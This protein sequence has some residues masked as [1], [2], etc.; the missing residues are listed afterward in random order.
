MNTLSS[1][2]ENQTRPSVKLH[3]ASLGPSLPS[4]GGSFEPERPT[5]SIRERWKAVAPTV[6]RYTC[7]G[8]LITEIL[9]LLDLLRLCTPLLFTTTGRTALLVITPL[10]LVYLGVLLLCML[11]TLALYPAPK[12]SLPFLA[13]VD[14]EELARACGS[15]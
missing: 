2:P 4:G 13:Q 1:G 14:P 7:R 10:L 15:P 5:A 8:A 12:P 3:T 11:A 6:L 9:C